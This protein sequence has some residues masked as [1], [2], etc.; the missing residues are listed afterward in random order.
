MKSDHNCPVLDCKWLHFHLV[1]SLQFPATIALIELQFRLPV[2]WFTG[3]GVPAFAH[4]LLWRSGYCKAILWLALYCTLKSVVINVQYCLPPHLRIILWLAHNLHRTVVVLAPPFLH[5]CGPQF[6]GCTPG[7]IPVVRKAPATSSVVRNHTGH[8]I[9][10]SHATSVPSC[11]CTTAA[12]QFRGRH[13][14]VVQI[15][16]CHA[17][18][19]QFRGCHA[20][21]PSFCGCHT[22]CTAVPWLSRHGVPNLWCTRHW[23]FL[24]T[25]LAPPPPCAAPCCRRHSLPAVSLAFPPPPLGPCC[26]RNDLPPAKLAQQPYES[27]ANFSQQFMAHTCGH[28][29]PPS[30]QKFGTLV[31]T[32]FADP[33][34]TCGKHLRPSAFPSAVPRADSSAIGSFAVSCPTASAVSRRSPR[35]ADLPVA[36]RPSACSSSSSFAF[37]SAVVL[38]IASPFGVSIPSSRPSSQAEI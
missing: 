33:W 7:I 29:P 15:R 25:H 27:R 38:A 26:L 18:A 28:L 17:T 37:A 21:A 3:C 20:S 35:V 10:G 30:A 24:T 22:T 32:T 12:L 16:G 2:H 11:G 31:R 19:Q 14:T 5:F 13:A 9:C 36:A 23:R 8:L 4:L 6:I 1:H 34:R